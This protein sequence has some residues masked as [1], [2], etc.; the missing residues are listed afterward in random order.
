[1]ETLERLEEAEADLKGDLKTAAARTQ[2]GFLKARAV[3]NDI[4]ERVRKLSEAMEER[5][6]SKR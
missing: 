5:A 2:A 6:R 3:L 4:E 1:M